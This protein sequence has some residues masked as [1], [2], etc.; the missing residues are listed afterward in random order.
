MGMQQLSEAS[1]GKF[2]VLGFAGDSAPDHVDQ[3][4]SLPVW[5]KWLR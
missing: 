2:L 5:L 4:N 1:H 3:L